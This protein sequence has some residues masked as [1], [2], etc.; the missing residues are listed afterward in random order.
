M[1]NTLETATTPVSATTIGSKSDVTNISMTKGP[2]TSQGFGT[3][4][5]VILPIYYL[6][7]S[8]IMYLEG[9]FSLKSTAFRNSNPGNLREYH[10]KGYHQGSGFQVFRSVLDGYNYLLSDIAANKGRTLRIY[11]SQKYAPA[12]EN[13]TNLYMQLVSQFSGMSLD[14]LIP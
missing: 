14:D 8:C 6:I 4:K 2:I 5:L 9:F 12:T 10:H 3:T 7:A 1:T 13:D 11:I